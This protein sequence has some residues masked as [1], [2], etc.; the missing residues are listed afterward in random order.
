MQEIVL[1]TK[2]LKENTKS[3]LLLFCSFKPFCFLSFTWWGQ[4]KWVNI[5]LV[6]PT[7]WIIWNFI[8]FLNF[9]YCFNLFL[10]SFRRGKYF[11]VGSSYMRKKKKFSGI[12][13]FINWQKINLI[14]INF[15]E[16]QIHHHFLSKV[17]T[18]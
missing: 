6:L 3:D 15:V 9:N 13:V 8:I 5:L 18:N 17:V 2:I 4:I 10:I 11:F 16:Q 12:H 1:A 14:G 7:F